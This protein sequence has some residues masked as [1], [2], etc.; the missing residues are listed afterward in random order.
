MS[1]AALIVLASLCLANYGGVAFQG[2]NKLGVKTFS[3]RP[4][5]RDALQSAQG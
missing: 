2:E 1:G 5:A 4:V 3:G